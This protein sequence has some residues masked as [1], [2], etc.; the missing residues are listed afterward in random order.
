MLKNFS[1]MSSVQLWS[2]SRGQ[3]LT[4][5][6]IMNLSSLTQHNADLLSLTSQSCSWLVDFSCS[7]LATKGLQQT[8]H[9][10]YEHLELPVTVVFVCSFYLAVRK[11]AN[12]HLV[13]GTGHRP[14]YSLRTLCR[15]L[16]YVAANP[17]HSVQRSLYE[18][19]SQMFPELSSNGQITEIQRMTI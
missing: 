18:V 14:H 11:E 13:D 8:Q 4:K 6:L 7:R 5:S 15:A 10:A 9:G 2:P 1:V 3:T 17:C 12:S 19:R 16:K